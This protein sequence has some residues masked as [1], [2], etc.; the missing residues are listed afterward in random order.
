[1]LPSLSSQ[2]NRSTTRTKVYLSQVAFAQIMKSMASQKDSW[3]KAFPGRN[4]F[5]RA[6]DLPNRKFSRI[7]KPKKKKSFRLRKFEDPGYVVAT[8]YK[9]ARNRP[10]DI[11][12]HGNT[13]TTLDFAS[14]IRHLQLGHLPAPIKDL[15]DARWKN[16]YQNDVNKFKSIP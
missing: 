5:K 1:M 2:R 13:P 16:S 4:G 10:T 11:T 15:Q 6:A 14:Y 12:E 9:L 7:I 3:T 8:N